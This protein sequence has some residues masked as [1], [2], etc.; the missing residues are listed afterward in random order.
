MASHLIFV[1]GTLQ[2][3]HRNA[4]I[5]QGRTLPGRYRTEQAWPLL[6]VGPAF[7][8]WLTETPG[9][10]LQVTGELVEV[11]D[12]ALARMDELEQLDRSDW[13]RRAPIVVRPEA[14]GEP[15]EA[16]AYFGSPR[17]VAMETVHAGP[18]AAYTLDMAARFAK[19]P[20]VLADAADDQGRLG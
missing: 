18:L 12:A 15:V 20:G 6:V 8:P 17:R 9:Q 1:Y 3:G 5:N 14:G 16:Q 10:G 11:D 13:Y 19:E 2:R 7:L 4:H